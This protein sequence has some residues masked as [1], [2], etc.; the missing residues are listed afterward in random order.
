VIR[1]GLPQIIGTTDT[2][3]VETLWSFA[4]EIGTPNIPARHGCVLVTITNMLTGEVRRRDC[5]PVSLAFRPAL[6][7]GSAAHC[8]ICVPGLPPVA[9][10]IE[11]I[12]IEDLLSAGYRLSITCATPQGTVTGFPL[13]TGS[14]FDKSRVEPR[15]VHDPT[16]GTRTGVSA[17]PVGHGG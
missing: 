10:V 13:G 2:T 7:I 1:E 3:I 4:D 8:H 14:V 5:D 16:T 9:A 15:R 11:E 6:L 17:D 12:P